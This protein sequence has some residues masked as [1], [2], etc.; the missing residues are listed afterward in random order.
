MTLSHVENIEHVRVVYPQSIRWSTRPSE[1]RRR[2]GHAPGDDR[3]RCS[4]C[5]ILLGAWPCPNP[6]C[7]ELHG[8]SAG[9]LCVWCRHKQEESWSQS[10]Q[11]T[12]MGESVCAQEMCAE[13][14]S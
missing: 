13:V 2:P 6:L 4:Q 10:L 7:P 1:E 8:Q 12:S 5:D 14:G 11:W 9:D 3:Q